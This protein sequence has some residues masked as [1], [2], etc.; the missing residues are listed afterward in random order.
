MFLIALCQY[1]V[2][3]CPICLSTDTEVTNSRFQARR[4]QTWRRRKCQSCGFTFT[5]RESL[6]PSFV[7][8]VKR[9]ERHEQFS[10]P[11]LALS[12]SRACNHLIDRQEASEALTD[13]VITKMM[14]FKDRTISTKQISDV[15]AQVL[16]NF[17]N[18][19]LIKY[20][21]FQ[22]DLS[23]ASSIKKQIKSKDS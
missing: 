4:Q 6:D 8:A 7:T 17:D 2:M 1:I 3:V 22:T 19:S 15:V 13:T 20:K 16:A 11:K 12:I 18:A 9:D 5:T 10:R 23:S 21:S 14:P